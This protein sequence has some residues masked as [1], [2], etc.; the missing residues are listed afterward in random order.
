MLALHSQNHSPTPPLQH[1]SDVVAMIEW[2]GAEAPPLKVNLLTDGVES[3][4]PV[5]PCPVLSW[6]S[7]KLRMPQQ[8]GWLAGWLVG[9]LDG[10]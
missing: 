6:K 5:L 1:S 3:S 7:L 2:C 4:E 8:A 10:W 9:W